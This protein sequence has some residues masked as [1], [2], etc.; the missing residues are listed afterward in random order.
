MPNDR[1]ATI[2][3]C[4]P[5]NPD[6]SGQPPVV[7]QALREAQDIALRAGSNDRHATWTALHQLE[8]DDLAAIQERKLDPE[9]SWLILT[10]E[11]R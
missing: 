9:L 7:D 1:P 5:M 6:H 11:V 10:A 8:D 4:I 2:V 3:V